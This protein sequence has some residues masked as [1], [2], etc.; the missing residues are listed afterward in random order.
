[1]KRLFFLLLCLIGFIH[2]AGAE[3]AFIQ[4]AQHQGAHVRYIETSNVRLQGLDKITARVLTLNAVIGETIQF[5]TLNIKVL[6]CL[7]TPPEEPPE[8]MAYLEISEVK[9]NLPL[10]TV[11]KG[12]I[13]S[14]NPSLSAPEHAVYDIWIK[15]CTDSTSSVKAL[16]DN[17]K[18]DDS[19]STSLPHVSP[20]AHVPLLSPE[21]EDDIPLTSSLSTHRSSPES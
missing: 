7:K 1:M 10:Y 8:S 14:T 5:G 11:F 2:K 19:Q 17:K 3:T 16:S 20:S 21:N 13:L 18:L 6:K 12:W 9:P 4:S 15:E